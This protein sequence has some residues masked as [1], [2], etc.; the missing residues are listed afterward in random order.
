MS[1]AYSK[2]MSRRILDYVAAGLLC[3]LELESHIEC[4]RRLHE[5][6]EDSSDDAKSKASGRRSHSIVTH[7]K[8]PLKFVRRL[9]KLYLDSYFSYLLALKARCDASHDD[10]VNWPVQER[11]INAFKTL[12]G[13]LSS[14]AV[15]SA[16]DEDQEFARITASVAASGAVAAVAVV[17]GADL[18]VASCGDCNMVLGSI[19]ENDTWVA[20][21]LTITHSTDNQNELKR[22]ESEH[23]KEKIKD[24]IRGDRLLG[25]LAPLRAFGDFKL[26]WSSE[27]IEAV[28]GQLLGSYA[29][30]QGYKS[31]PY[32]SV[33]PEVVHHRLT[34][35]DKFMVIATDGLWDMMTP[36]QVIRLVGEHMSGKITLTPLVLGQ[37]VRT[38]QASLYSYFFRESHSSKDFHYTWAFRTVCISLPNMIYIILTLYQFPR[39]PTSVCVRSTRFSGTARRQ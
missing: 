7:V 5:N 18:Y 39:R 34:T 25:I 29:V 6:G 16:E 8:Y 36:M 22:I 13:D 30:P 23:P 10:F 15:G 20:K 32:L 17:D 26:K 35:R 21:K 33:E 37:Q 24:I 14:E 11:L 1:H 38:N 9:E 4:V 2:V 28:L 12:D 19:S 31:P 27:T 3:P